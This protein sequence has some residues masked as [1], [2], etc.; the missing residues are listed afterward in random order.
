M[1]AVVQAAY[2][3]IGLVLLD[4]GDSS[5]PEA[6]CPEV[7]MAV[8]EELYRLSDSQQAD[9]PESDS[10]DCEEVAAEVL[11]D[12]AAADKAAGSPTKKRPEQK[13]QA[14]EEQD[15]DRPEARNNTETVHN[16]DGLDEVR[17]RPCKQ[18]RLVACGRQQSMRQ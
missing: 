11:S 18:L 5:L 12:E 2:G 3:A 15:T 1:H 10:E 9:E 16:F 7:T 13:E 14:S 6:E 4:T 17:C 8:I